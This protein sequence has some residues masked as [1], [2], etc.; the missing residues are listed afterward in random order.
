MPPSSEVERLAAVS[1]EMGGGV[2]EE[3]TATGVTPIGLPVALG[4]QQTEGG[5]GGQ[6]CPKGGQTGKRAELKSN[7]C[8]REELMQRMQVA[9]DELT[10]GPS[11]GEGG[12]AVHSPNR[13]SG[14]SRPGNSST[15]YMVAEPWDK[16][17]GRTIDGKSEY[18]VEVP[19]NTERL[20]GQA[21]MSLVQ[22]WAPDC[23]T[24]SR[25]LEKPI[26][27]APEGEG[28]QPL[29]TKM[30][31]RGLPTKALNAQ[32]GPRRAKIIIEKLKLHNLMA[33]LAAQECIKAVK[34]GRFFCLENPGGSWI[35][36]LPEYKELA[37][38]AGVVWFT[39]HN[40]AFGGKRRKYTGMLTNIPGLQETLERRC[41][42]R[43]DADVCDFSG[44]AHEA[45]VPKWTKGFGHTVTQAESEYPKAM[46][47]AMAPTVVACAAVAPQLAARLPYAFLEVFSGPNAPLTQGVRRAMARKRQEPEKQQ[48]PAGGKPPPRS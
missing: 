43:G 21:A 37:A 10:P 13:N 20:R 30:H 14:A 4:P 39:F 9:M 3:R 35:W 27:G 42:A 38:M 7:M 47:E 32:F 25:A 6:G 40:C 15:K 2:R 11:G 28:P 22:H 26:P 31:L 46:C 33:E 44:W 23:S 5:S 41:N 18:D 36:Q 12:V 34:E 48:G 45:W 24:F 1:S 19:A 17:R 29:R 16:L 8:V